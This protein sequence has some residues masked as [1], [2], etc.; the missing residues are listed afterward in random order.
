MCGIFCYLESGNENR[1]TTACC[2]AAAEKIAH[3]GPDNN[4]IERI[5]VDSK[6]SVFSSFHR[7]CI[8]GLDSSSNQPIRGQETTSNSLSPYLMCNG[9]IYNYR[10]LIK[11][12]NLEPVT[13]SDCEVILLLYQKTRDIVKTISLLDGVFACVIVDPFNKQLHIARDPIGVRPLF[14]SISEQALAVGS[15]LKCLCKFKDVVVPFPPN[16]VYSYSWRSGKITL[17]LSHFIYGLG[18]EVT[19]I[20]PDRKHRALYDLLTDAVTKRVKNTERPLGLLLSGGLDSS[21]IAALAAR[22]SKRQL[23]SFSFAITPNDG[24]TSHSPDIH[25][26]QKV[27]DF[28][29]TKHHTITVTV[30]EALNAIPEVIRCTETWDLTTI[31]ASTPMWLLVKWISENTDIKV[32]LSGEGSD[33]IFGGYLYFHYAKSPKE[34]QAETERLVNELYMYD[35]LRADRC[36]AAHGLELR[37]PFLD[38]SLVNYVLSLP[39]QEKMCSNG[40]I[41]KHILRKV[42]EFSPN[43]NDLLG[44]FQKLLP[45]E[46]TW[47]Q[48]DAFSDAVGFCWVESIKKHVEKLN[49]TEAE[50]YLNLFEREYPGRKNVIKDYWMPRWTNATDPSATVLDVFVKDKNSSLVL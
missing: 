41:E 8:N 37:V 22:K 39:P 24:N 50:W 26:A 3:R 10:E 46:I 49:L 28:I 25:Y 30:E 38:K 18:M 6:F 16:S 13:N 14:Y 11:E 29:G 5:S 42:S 4:T 43:E 17:D 1:M 45:D 31:R 19:T 40:K 2:H 44:K 7:L 32:L 27:A 15:E 36:T 20:Q 23:H 34:F 21:I 47:R 12:Y 33:E 35:V 9:E 48:K